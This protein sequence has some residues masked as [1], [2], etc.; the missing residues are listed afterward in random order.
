MGIL[1]V[2]AIWMVVEAEIEFIASTH[3]TAVPFKPMLTESMDN[4]TIRGRAPSGEFLVRVNVVE[5][6]MIG[7]DC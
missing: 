6:T 5:F 1:P 4:V 7:I 3:I 2:L